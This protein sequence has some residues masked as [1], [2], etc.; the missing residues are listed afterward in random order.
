MIEPLGLILDRAESS[1]VK[2]NVLAM[3]ICFLE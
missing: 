1:S 2:E 3:F